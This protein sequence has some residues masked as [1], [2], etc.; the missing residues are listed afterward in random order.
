MYVNFGFYL[1]VLFF[2]MFKDIIDKGLFWD[3]V[4]NNYVYWYDY[5][6]DYEE[7]NVVLVG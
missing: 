4:L 7:F 6:V 5:E 2:K 1:Y 3:F